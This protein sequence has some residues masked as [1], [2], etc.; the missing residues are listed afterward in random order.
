MWRVWGYDTVRLE[1]GKGRFLH[2]G[3][4][5]GAADPMPGSHVVSPRMIPMLNQ[6]VS[7]GFVIEDLSDEPIGEEELDAFLLEFYRRVIDL[8]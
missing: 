5:D 2:I 8:G 1:L 3:V 6:A 4:G 7:F